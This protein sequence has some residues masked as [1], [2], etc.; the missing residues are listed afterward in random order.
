[1]S[2]ITITVSLPREQAAGL[3]RFT[4]KMGHS[5]ALTVLYPH[6]PAVLRD[7]QAYQIVYALTALER[8]LIG[9]GVASWPWIET[10]AP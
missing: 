8:A 7:E 1:M 6:K 9:A 4:Q 3:L 5:D 10:G 2:D